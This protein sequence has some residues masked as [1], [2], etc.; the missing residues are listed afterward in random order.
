M[1]KLKLF[2][3][4]FLFFSSNF[5][6]AQKKSLDHSVYDSWES[7]GNRVLSN[8]GKWLGYSKDVQEGDG[9]LL[10]FATDKKTSQNFPRANKLAITSDSKFAVFSVRPF[11]KDIKAV[12]DKKLKKNKLTKD[13]LFIVNLQNS[14]TA[15]IPNVKSYK[16]PIKGGSVVA[17]LLENLKDKS[18][19]AE[20]DD[21]KED[22]GDDKNN[23]PSELII[24][25]LLTG[26]KQ[27]FQNVIRYEFS[28]NGKQ[29]AFVTQKPEEKNDD[30][31][32]KE[33]VKSKDKSKPKKY[34]LQ[35][36]HL[37]NLENFAVNKLIEEEGDFSQLSFDKSG[38][39]FSLVGTTSAEN[40]LVKNYNLYYFSSNKK[41]VLNHNSLKMPKG[42]V[43]SENKMPTF[44][45][46][47][48]QL[49]FGIAPKP[50]A[51]D[52]ALITNDHAILDIWSHNDDYL[53]TIQLKNL[54]KDLKKSYDAVIQTQNPEILTAIT[55]P[56]MDSIAIIN[57]GNAPFSVGISNNNS[58]A[59]FQWTGAEKNTYFI[60]NNLSGETTEFV[61]NLN[62]RVYPS[63]LGNYM[64]YFNR[65]DGNWYA[66]NVVKKSTFQL[67]KGLQVK[68][69]NEEFDMPDY[70]NSYGLEGFTDL[71]FSVIIKD[72]YDLWEFFL[73]GKSAPKNITNGF[74]RKNKISFDM[75]QLDKDIKSYN[76]KTEMYLFA[77]NEENKQ[78]GIFKSKIE[79]SKNPELLQMGDFYGY[80]NLIKAKNAEVYSYTKESFQ[81]SPNVYV[82]DYF[83]TEHQ[84]SKINPQQNSYN[85]GT[86]ELVSWTT[87]KGYS[88]KG[89]LYKPE[90]FDPNKKY[91]M[92]VYFY[93]KLSDGLN[94]YIAP[95]P[96]PSRLNI[97]FFVSNEYL[98]FAPDI[99]YEDGHPGQSAVEF[100]NSGVE[101]LKK[102][103]WVNGDKIGIQGQ[104][105][106]GYQVAYLITHNDM[107]AAAWSGAP[108]VNMTSAYGGIR[109]STGM[110][111]QFQYER[112]QSR[113]GKTLWEAPELY[114]ENSPLF[115]LDKV[116]TPVVI[117]SNDKDGAVPWYQGIEM[118]TALKRLDKK[119]WLLNYNNDDHNLTKRQNR[120]DIQIRE[121]QFFDY[122]LKDAKAPVW[123]TRGI[124]STLKGIDWGFELTDE[125][126]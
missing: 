121:Q 85:W 24:E 67:N 97:S 52:T 64:V 104:S 39:H 94:R 93:E 48:K 102:N 88:S 126:P 89:I 68:F 101:Y 114:I 70:P 81:N 58:R 46:N 103:P 112:S 12:K 79:A 4:C 99:S 116:T 124:P 29:L 37:M 1:L 21:D 66:Y 84:V 34:A 25:N 31:K 77:F 80:K 86:A 110:N 9:T 91:P 115:H 57:E 14:K 3:F 111:R 55:H 30:A 7:I 22:A 53:K 83:K 51:K 106:G 122:Y 47:G 15:K 119:V 56:K 41:A 78:S 100:I 36:V 28:E 19:E 23:K 123:M 32:D 6:I 63:P 26:K 49:Y 105:W 17:Y 90:N 45:K 59:E 33:K 87:P 76:R 73:D 50:I 109:W 42:W 61:K 75:Y 71:D 120:K 44:S 74:G 2:L 72:R 69:T 96:T 125:K 54:S 20:K 16:I 60:V 108:V 92:I 13:S 117:M 82:S 118:F 27:S 18:T 113:I 95:A 43:I 38:N 5:I 62:G 40:D 11:Y 10:L 98:V 35:S 107:Y 8:D 65:E